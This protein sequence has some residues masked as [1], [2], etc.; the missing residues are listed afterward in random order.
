MSAARWVEAHGARVA[1]IESQVLLGVSRGEAVQS[2]HEALLAA[3]KGSGAMTPE[4]A[5]AIGKE[6]RTGPWTADQL[7]EIAKVAND[8]LTVVPKP[9]Q[10]TR[11]QR[12]T[13]ELCVS[14]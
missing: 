9:T 13:Q 12:S 2:Q 1:F 14:M 11:S 3:L 8:A 10:R 5:T 7:R 4:D 6:W